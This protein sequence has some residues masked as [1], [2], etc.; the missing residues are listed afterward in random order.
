MAAPPFPDD[1][2]NTADS[3]GF[4]YNLYTGTTQDGTPATGIAVT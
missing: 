3:N 4:N 1:T 2:D